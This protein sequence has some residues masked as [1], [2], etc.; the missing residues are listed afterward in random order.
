MRD[1][2]G[3]VERTLKRHYILKLVAPSKSDNKDGSPD[4]N[5]SCLR[6]AAVINEPDMLQS[7]FS[8]LNL[9]TKMQNF[10]NSRLRDC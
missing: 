10:A 8:R 1:T 4:N 2:L 6:C 5:K 7:N 9:C 3:P